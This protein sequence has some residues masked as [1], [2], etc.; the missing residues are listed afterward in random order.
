MEGDGKITAVV[1]AIILVGVV[2]RLATTGALTKADR[3]GIGAGFVVVGAV[4]FYDVV[5][6]SN[7]ASELEAGANG[8]AQVSTG[9]RLWLTLVAAA[10]GIVGAAVAAKK[11]NT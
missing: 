9:T 4:A 10:L 2:V 1:G 3:S 6:V 8:L 5:N 7:K 11:A